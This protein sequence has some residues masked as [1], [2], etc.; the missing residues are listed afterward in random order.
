MEVLAY[1]GIGVLVILFII[2]ALFLFG[3]VFSLTRDL[4]VARKTIDESRVSNEVYRIRKD[5]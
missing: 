1:F 3:Y 4:L 5:V 2:F